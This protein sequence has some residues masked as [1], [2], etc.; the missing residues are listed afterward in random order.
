MRDQRSA[1]ASGSR[2]ARDNVGE[3]GGGGEDPYSFWDEGDVERGDGR[4]PADGERSTAQKVIYSNRLIRFEAGFAAR[5]EGDVA[6]LHAAAPS[7][8]QEC[9]DLAAFERA[10]IQR[11]VDESVVYH[12]GCK[13]CHQ[14]LDL[15]CQ[16]DVQDGEARKTATTVAAARLAG[17]FVKRLAGPVVEVWGRF[18]AM[19]VELPLWYCAECETQEV[20][21]APSAPSILCIPSSPTTTRGLALAAK[22]GYTKWVRLDALRD[23]DGFTLESG[24]NMSPGA[25]ASHLKR[26]YD[27]TEHCAK[28]VGAAGDWTAP[29]ISEVHLRNTYRPYYLIEYL[30]RKWEKD[31][32]TFC[33]GA[34]PS[35]P[36]CAD[37]ILRGGRVDIYR[38]LSFILDGCYSM[39]HNASAAPTARAA[40]FKPEIRN[41]F[42]D[43]NDRAQERLQSGAE[44]GP[45]PSSTW[46]NH[47]NCSKSRARLFFSTEGG[48]S[49]LHL[50]RPPFLPRC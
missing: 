9:V 7:A 2:Q 44:A 22:Y 10:S 1:A 3:G 37:Q 15:L 19:M 17:G 33:A 43:V 31:L 34:A 38:L 8:A 29:H 12:S 30:Q 11:R 45:G 21:A 18:S 49:R 27:Y 20:A 13:H 39:G 46:H 4:A 16:I 6:A 42:G 5:R 50:N 26:T 40:G 48:A 47:L 23:F 14:E 36:T 41:L 35:C 25:F 32:F 28:C 24:K